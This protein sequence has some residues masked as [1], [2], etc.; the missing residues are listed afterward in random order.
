MHQL[1][2]LKGHTFRHYAWLIV[3]V[4]SAAQMLGAGLGMALGGLLPGLV[5]DITG[6]YAWA[7]WLSAGFSL[8]GAASILMLEPTKR[9]LIPRWEH[10]T[11]KG[12][13]VAPA[14]AAADVSF[15]D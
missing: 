9:P 8:F 3:V 5:F 11:D 14:R 6:G 4:A 15:A 10:L 7:I 1:P 12:T 2:G 13:R